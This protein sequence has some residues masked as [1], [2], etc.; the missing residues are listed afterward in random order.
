MTKRPLPP[1][2]YEMPDG[3]YRAIASL[4]GVD[5]HVG[6]FDAVPAAQ[7]ARKAVVAAWRKENSG[8]RDTCRALIS[9][10]LD[11]RE[12]AGHRA[13]DDDRSRVN[14]H[15][16]TA[17]WADKPLRSVKSS[18]IAAWTA[19][20][21]RKTAAA[22]PKAKTKAATKRLSHQT[23]RHC[24][25]LARKFFDDMRRAGRCSGANPA[26]GVQVGRREATVKPRVYLLPEE[27]SRLLSLP[28]LPLRLRAIYTTAIYT[29]LRASELWA[30]SWSDMHTEPFPHFYVSKSGRGTTKSSESRIVP[31]L[32]VVV[33]VLREWQRDSA[34]I[35]SALVFAC[36]ARGAGKGWAGWH[37]CSKGYDAEWKTWARKHAGITMPFKQC[38]HTCGSHLVM[39]TWG[40]PQTLE[41]VAKWLGH[42]D[43]RVTYKHYAHLAPDAVRRAY[44]EILASW[45]A[46]RHVAGPTKDPTTD[47]LSAADARGFEPLTFGSGGRVKHM[48]K[49]GDRHGK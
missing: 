42:K 40:K 23:R 1:G 33:E 27:I 12:L 15:V 30:L 4:G 28:N 5:T 19:E 48:K 2:I 29:G 31:L 36:G 21:E 16:L 3:R 9:D 10:W 32:P 11:E 38:R 13:V 49:R 17:A 47:R 22:P 46:D 14:R 20:L 37:Q 34:R 39:G 45:E 24:L 26:A 44:D 43:I 41:Y 8:P 7:R 6:Y 18:D 35:G 25:N